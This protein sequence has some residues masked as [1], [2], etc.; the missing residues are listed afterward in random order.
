M[1]VLMSTGAALVTIISVIPVLY[2]YGVLGHNEAHESLGNFGAAWVELRPTLDT[3]TA[4]GDTVHFAATIADKKGSI[5]V[6]AAPTWTTGDSSVATVGP[7]GSVVARGPGV[8]TVSVVVGELVSHAHIMV[9]PHVAVVVAT[10]SL[11]DTAVVLREGGQTPLHARPLDARGHEV[12][13]RVPVWHIDDST[14]AKLDA[15]GVLTG[16]NAGRTVASAKVDGM[17]GYLTIAVVTTASDLGV[18]AGANQHALAGHLLPQ[19]VV[20]RAT[21]R[22][23]APVSGKLVTFRVR[24]TQ[25]KVDPATDTTDADGRARTQW[26][27]GDDPGAQALLARVE[28]VDSVTTIAAEAD[29]VARNTRVAPIAASLRARAGEVLGD[30]VA[31]LVTDSTGRVLPGVPVRWL[32]VDGTVDAMNARTDSVG[33]AH[34]RWTLSSKTGTQHLHA[35]VGGLGSHVPPTVLGAVALSGPAAKMLVVSGDRQHASAG[36]KLGEPIV[37]RV[38]D[39]NGNG[40]A[41][42]PVVLSLS[43]G[44]VQDTSLVTDSL[45]FAKTHWIMGNAAGDYTLAAHVDGL[46]KLLKVSAHATAAAPANLSF[47]D[48]PA[49]KAVRGTRRLVALVTDIY[50][51]PVAEAPVTFNVKS[52]AVSPTRAV[53][54]AHGHVMVRWMVGAGSSNQTLKGTVRGTDVTGAYVSQIVQAGSPRDATLKH[55]KAAP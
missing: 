20:V 25:G 9:T 23:G 33:I 51:N 12:Q 5:L 38:V 40:A 50:G 21:D 55:K 42:V 7:D 26:T 22:K 54:D 30:S 52:G 48:A 1:A 32:A 15:N 18:V 27:L 6:G 41:D 43:G 10:N 44:D 16:E 46:K 47:D 13:G 14:V 49:G 35:L 34:A 36:K 53:T 4:I 29:P 31:V 2:S 19:Q 37:L 17:S 11:G 28:N 3:A 45:G 24:G 39:A 8:T